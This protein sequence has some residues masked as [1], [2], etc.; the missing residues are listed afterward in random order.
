[1]GQVDRFS[2]SLDTELLAAF[3]RYLAAKGYENRS[4]AIRD[5]IRD[6]LVGDRRIEGDRST[7]AVL[8]LVCDHRVGEVAARLRTLLA[9]HANLVRGSLHLPADEHRD[10]LAIALHGPG[11]Q[12]QQ[13]ADKIQAMR[14][15]AHGHLAVFPTE[16]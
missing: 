13:I 8:T 12:V 14:G 1:M 15:I 7:T 10:G 9:A 6:L 2:V 16:E 4:E 11:D 3:D 5:M